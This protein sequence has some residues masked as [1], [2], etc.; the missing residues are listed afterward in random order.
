MDIEQAFKL[1]DTDGSGE[2]S[3]V[4]FRK[5]LEDL[6]IVL[7]EKD[8]KNIFCIFDIDKNGQISLNELKS[9]LDEFQNKI[10]RK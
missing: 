3:Q 2:I 10:N 7:N 4:E 8:F 5:G 9:T 6:K 1:I